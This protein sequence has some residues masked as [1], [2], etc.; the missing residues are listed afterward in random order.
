[1]AHSTESMCLRR[2]ALA[3]QDSMSA[4]AT[5]R[6]GS[7]EADMK[8]GESRVNVSTTLMNLNG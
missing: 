1:M 7:G 4:R 3:V 6:V 2:D 5:S 8:K